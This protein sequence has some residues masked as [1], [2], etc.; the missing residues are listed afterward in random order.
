MFD[1]N[2]PTPK[3]KLDIIIPMEISGNQPI[4]PAR[5]KVA[6]QY[7]DFSKQGFDKFARDNSLNSSSKIN[8]NSDYL[9][10]KSYN[11]LIDHMITASGRGD[12]KT[13]EDALYTIQ[14]RFSGQHV[15]NALSKYSQLL[16]NASINE[17]REELIKQAMRRGDLIRTKNSFDLYS[18]KYGKPLSK[19]DFDYKG[20]LIPKYRAKNQNLEESET[21]G[22][23]TSQIKLT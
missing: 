12:L 22:I 11:E 15:V 7:Y 10:T 21:I 2:F 6:N 13:A 5:F 9:E 18:P 16:K 20:N 3:G 23:N 17:E 1:V 19:L 8:L 4:P 14:K